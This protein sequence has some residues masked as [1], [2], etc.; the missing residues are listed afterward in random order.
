MSMPL[1]FSFSS[2]PVLHGFHVGGARAATRAL[3]TVNLK[4]SSRTIAWISYEIC[5]QT[6]QHAGHGQNPSISPFQ[7][8]F[9]EQ[10][11]P[12]L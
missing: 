7:N 2:S 1:F 3:Q 5:Y 4:N 6:R 9:I 10:S 12:C 8:V 11:H